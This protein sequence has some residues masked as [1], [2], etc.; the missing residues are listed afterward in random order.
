MWPEVSV[1]PSKLGP[2]SLGVALHLSLPG[3]PLSAFTVTPDATCWRWQDLRSLGPQVAV[4]CILC[5]FPAL[6]RYG[7]ELWGWSVS[8]AEDPNPSRIQNHKAQF[9]SPHRPQ[10]G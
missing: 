3:R 1:S 2:I 10:R 7:S 9:P 6:Q 5:N 8:A 4:W